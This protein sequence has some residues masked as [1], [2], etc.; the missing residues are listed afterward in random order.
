MKPRLQFRQRTGF[1]LTELL[2]VIAIITILVALLLP[3]IAAVKCKAYRVVC[4][5][6]N[7]QIGVAVHLYAMN[8][9]D[10]LPHPNWR[11]D[12]GDLYRGWLYTPTN[13][14]PPNM[15]KAPLNTN[16]LPAWTMSSANRWRRR[17]WSEC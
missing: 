14:N 13:R 17:P 9:R 1:T 10:Y 3:A 6:N 4:L 12:I 15:D 5:N 8:N 11:D 16:P 7:R 2:V